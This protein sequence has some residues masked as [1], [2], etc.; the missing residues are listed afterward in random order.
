MARGKMI[1]FSKEG[2][3][4]WA[5]ADLT[6]AYKQNGALAVRRGV[7]LV[8]RK[9]LVIKDEC[10]LESPSE[11]WWFMHTQATIELADDGKSARLTTN[12]KTTEARLLNAPEGAR[13]SVMEAVRLPQS[14]APAPGERGGKGYTKLAVKMEG[15]TE[16]GLVV[17]LLPPSAQGMRV[18]TDDLPLSR[19]DDR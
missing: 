3:S 10:M 9:A 15:V 6:D 17:A 19:W 2:S 16:V 1:G 5:I 12:G 14:P 18:S 7:K 8:D 11:V 4:P 13:F